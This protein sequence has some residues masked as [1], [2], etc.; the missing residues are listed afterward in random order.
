MNTSNLLKSLLFLKKEL[1]VNLSILLGAAWKV[2]V[3]F[4]V[5]IFLYSDDLI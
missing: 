5:R 4:M 3:F 1:P 2:S